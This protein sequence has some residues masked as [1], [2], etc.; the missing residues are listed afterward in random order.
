ML[1]E[2]SCKIVED[3]PLS[4][5]TVTRRIHDLVADIKKKHIFQLHI[6]HAYSLQLDEST[7]VAG[8]AVL[9]IFVSYDFDKII[10]E[11]LLLCDFLRTNTTGE[12]IFNCIDNFMK[13]RGIR[14]EKMY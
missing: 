8:L 6:C 7:N 11:D 13:T 2:E 14:W 9:H 12:N 3:V 4:N 5:S 1:D 10:E